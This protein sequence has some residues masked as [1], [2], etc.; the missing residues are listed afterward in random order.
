[1]VK[2]LDLDLLEQNGEID[3]QVSYGTERKMDKVPSKEP[4]PKSD[5]TTITKRI[6]WKTLKGRRVTVRAFDTVL[7]AGNPR[8][9]QNPGNGEEEHEVDVSDL[10]PKIKFTG[11]NSQAVDARM[12]DGK[13]QVIAGKRRRLSCGKLD[14][15]LTCDVYDDVTDEDAT[16]IAKIENEG[17][18][19][20]DL[21]TM[22]TYLYHRFKEQKEVNPNLTIEAFAS[23]FE[24]SERT[25]LDR[26]RLAKLPEWIKDSCADRHSWTVRQA[27]SLA[28]LCEQ[29]KSYSCDVS[30]F[31][32]DQRF[33]LSTPSL[34]LT[35]LKAY[36]PS[37]GN[38]NETSLEDINITS[39]SK[40]DY[41]LA[42]SK[43][44]EVTVKSKTKLS[45]EQLGKL[46]EFLKTL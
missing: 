23:K 26:F 10:L 16:Y 2:A 35:K 4:K 41:K 22:S 14:L 38:T 30:N 19:D 13:I 8:N 34:V 36:L 46:Q 18:K 45:E 44:G 43:K 15:E 25:M 11:G 28:A 42:F 33:K 20:I 40:V 27:N 9:F 21:L 3:K 12:V 39:S 29:L 31:K 37:T 24:M 17:R 5:G 6:P 32:D 7:W 1:M